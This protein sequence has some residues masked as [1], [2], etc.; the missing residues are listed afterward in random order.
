MKRKLGID[1]DDVLIDFVTHL[2]YFHN[3]KYNTSLKKDDITTWD[4]HTVWGV[5]EEEAMRRTLEFVVSHDHTNILPMNDAVEV[6]HRLAEHFE[7]IIITARDKTVSHTAYNLIE[8]HFGNIFSSVH[9]LYED[10]VK[11][12]TKGLVCKNLGIDFFVD[13]SV[14]NIQH[15]L[16]AGIISFL[17]DAPWNRHWNNSQVRRITSWKEIE[18][19]LTSIK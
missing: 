16:E 17:F 11:K 12:G 19:I 6:L 4:L 8:K 5:S 2:T 1:F 14:A 7:L 13:D 15:T 9:F 3:N 10:G 18:T